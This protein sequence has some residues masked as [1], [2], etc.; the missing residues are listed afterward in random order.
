M[1]AH[2][3]AANLAELMEELQRQT[4]A[5]LRPDDSGDLLQFPAELGR[6]SLWGMRVQTGFD[7]ILYDYAFTELL[8]LEGEYSGY[9]QLGFGF[10]LSG[11]VEYITRGSKIDL[12][13]RPG[14]SVLSFT[15]DFKGEARYPAG[16]RIL[17]TGIGV[18]PSV[19]ATFLNGQREG[20]PS[21]LR[22][23][24]DGATAKLYFQPGTITPA[25]RVALT[26][27]VHCPYQGVTKRLYLE[28][29]A[30][31]LV[32]LSLTQSEV[33]ERRAFRSPVLRPDD[34]ERIYK[35]K[36]VLLDN[37]DEPPSLLT[38][39]RQVGL[40]DFKL[41]A[42]FRQVFGTTAFGYLHEQRMERARQ[43]LEERR[44]NVTEVA[45]AVGYANPSHFAGAFKRKFGVNPSAYLKE[46]SPTWAFKRCPI[47][48]NRS[49]SVRPAK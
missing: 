28:S 44:F 5:I 13:T 21:A 32:A 4:G 26:Q 39:A 34:I 43:L 35:A 18:E 37:M 14:Q 46:T 15:P 10:C 38:L 9:R 2:I 8:L 7:L 27:V 25:I 48:G 1:R 24:L 20:L 29:K 16:Q 42:G 3:S 6:G 19:F 45:C 47:F 41:K 33:G 17:M 23:I 22:R 12:R 31:E 40:N 11:E 36:D 30:L 49:P